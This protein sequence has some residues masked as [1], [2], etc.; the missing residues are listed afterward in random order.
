M[1]TA[2]SLPGICW[3]HGM[4]TMYHHNG[5][6]NICDDLFSHNY[7]TFF[8]LANI[9]LLQCQIRKFRCV[10]LHFISLYCK[11]GKFIMDCYSEL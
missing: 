6:K 4:F 10:Y 11:K 5:D 8:G 2:V 3:M 1:S 7:N 9:K